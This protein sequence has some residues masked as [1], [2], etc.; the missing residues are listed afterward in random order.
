MIAKVSA[1]AISLQDLDC[2]GPLPL[3]GG[4]G[5]A[6]L[7]LRNSGDEIGGVAGG[8]DPKEDEAWEEPACGSEPEGKEMPEGEEM[9]EGAGEAAETDANPGQDGGGEGGRGMDS[10]PKALPSSSSSF[11]KIST[12]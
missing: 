11:S 9:P 1:P 8:I 3:P 10:T 12:E 7:W 4:V 2:P 5:A 6:V